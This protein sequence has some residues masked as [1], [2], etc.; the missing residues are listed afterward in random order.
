M[1]LVFDASMT[2]SWLFR[3]EHTD[4]AHRIMSQVVEEGSHV[5]SLWRLE[6]ANVLRQAVRRGRS[7]EVFVDRCL[8]RLEAMSIAT[9]RETDKQA[10]GAI[11]AIAREERLTV[12][13]AAY[14][15][16]ALRRRLPLA[17]CD[18]ELV[19]AAARRNVVVFGIAG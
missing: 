18:S 11:L 6:V 2:L 14:R 15:E 8:S 12:Y 7:D 5:P 17:S 1:S 19:A 16:L 13:D 3:D 10:W 4:R 9:D